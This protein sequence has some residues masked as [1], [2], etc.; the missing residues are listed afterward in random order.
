[1]V[2]TGTAAEEPDS[3]KAPI[4]VDGYAARQMGLSKLTRF[5]QKQV[6]V[7]ELRRRARS[8]HLNLASYGCPT[9]QAS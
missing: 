8:A 4:A 3:E 6:V 2:A 5:Y 9:P 7:Y 1:V